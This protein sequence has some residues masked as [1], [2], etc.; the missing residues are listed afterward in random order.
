[1][2]YSYLWEVRRV[3]TVWVCV[4]FLEKEMATHSSTLAW[5]ILWTE[6][7]RSLCS[8]WGPQRVGHDWASLLS[9]SLRADFW[10]LMM[11]IS[12]S[13]EVSL[14][15]RNS[16]SCTLGKVLCILLLAIPF[17]RGSSQSRSWTQIP[18]IAGRFFTI[19]ATREA[20][21]MYISIKYYWIKMWFSFSMSLYFL[22]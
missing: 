19:W 3:I 15:G 1:M 10:N 9:L 11:L 13:G 21:C 12:W 20:I 4:D 22:F 7:P 5:K 6:E 14:L 8:P 16:L 2:K 18:C 17:S